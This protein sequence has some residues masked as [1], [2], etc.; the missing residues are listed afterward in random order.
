[1]D[2]PNIPH[3]FKK[4]VGD[5]ESLWRR[6]YNNP[7]FP[8][9][10]PDDK[11][12]YRVSSAAFKDRN[13]ELSVDIA[14]KTTID[15]CLAG[16]PRGDALASIK[17]K[18]PKGF[19]YPVIEDPLPNNPAHALIKGKIKRSHTKLLAKACQWVV[20]PRFT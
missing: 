18:I 5:N 16:P 19:G 4:P 3:S 20:E 13:N 10:K 9:Y 15:K 11:G 2:V 1:M 14:S 6:I 17:A 12:G 8:Q 7:N